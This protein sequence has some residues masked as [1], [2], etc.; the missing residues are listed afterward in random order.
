M[1]RTATI[2]FA[3]LCESGS[4]TYFK[5]RPWF[6]ASALRVDKTP[7][8]LRHSGLGLTVGYCVITE[9]W[10]FEILIGR[11]TFDFFRAL[12]YWRRP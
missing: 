9:V 1:I 3:I 8:G 5:R 4:G 10:V 6:H 7:L 11:W 12:Y 2:Q